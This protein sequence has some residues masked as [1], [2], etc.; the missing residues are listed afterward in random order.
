M[1]SVELLVCTILYLLHHRIVAKCIYFRVRYIAVDYALIQNATDV[2]ETERQAS[3]LP[4]RLSRS[5][6]ACGRPQAQ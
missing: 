5:E 2:L 1:A 4:M 3:H 6:E